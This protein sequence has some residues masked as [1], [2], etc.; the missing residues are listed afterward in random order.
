[1]CGF[2]IGNVF[3]DKEQFSKSLNL[4]DHRGK[5]NK[6]VNYSDK[7]NTWMGHNRLSIQGL[8]DDSNQPMYKS[9]YTI[10]YN[11]ELWKSMK[12]TGSDTKLLLDLFHANQENCI[13]SLDGMFGFAVLDEGENKLTFARDFMGRIPLYYYKIDKQIVVASELKSITDT[14]NVNAS[15]VSLVEPGCY[16]VFDYNTGNL[17]QTRFYE[18][19]LVTKIEDMSEEYVMNG[20]RDLL[21]EG[22]DN[23]LISD[24]PVCTILSG[25]V[26]STIITYLLKQRIPNLQAFVVSMGDTGKKDDLHYARIA[27]REIGVPLHEIIIDKD[28]VK[29]NLYEAIYAIEDYKWT[30][31]S[32]AVAQLALAK[33]IHDEGFKVV[34]GGE[35]SDELFASY[36]DV[37]AWH[38]KDEDYIKKRYKLIVDLHKNNLIRTNKAMMYGGTVELR[39]P[40]LHKNL[41]EFCLKIPPKYKKEGQMW[42][43]MLRKAFKN[44]LSDELLFRPKKTFQEGCHTSYLKNHKDKIKDYYMS[45]YEQKNSLEEFMT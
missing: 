7:T 14:L 41:V 26:D 16:Y 4:I 31:V 36:G 21:V 25:G 22:V 15:D 13:A 10:V 19:P 8:N 44:E 9:P 12:H 24:V 30:Q 2:V 42:K 11:G 33:K 5:D 39:T 34:F 6:G 28:W 18:F 23:E 3:T 40:F 38:Y 20:I 1:M 32:P 45:H 27:S 29:Q 17:K 43:P 37:F 35:G